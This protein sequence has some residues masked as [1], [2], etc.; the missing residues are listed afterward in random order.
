M[1]QGLAACVGRYVSRKTFAYSS[2][3]RELLAHEEGAA[4]NITYTLIQLPV[5][6]RR[7]CCLDIIAPDIYSALI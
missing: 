4:L 6:D 1:K 5:M 2:G 3:M 7:R